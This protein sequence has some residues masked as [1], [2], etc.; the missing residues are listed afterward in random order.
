MNPLIARRLAAP[1]DGTSHVQVP[2]AA[3]ARHRIRCGSGSKTAA[4]VYRHAT[5][6]TTNADL[7]QSFKQYAEINGCEFVLRKND[8]LDALEQM[9]FRDSAGTFQLK[10]GRTMAARGFARLAINRSLHLSTS[11]SPSTARTEPIGAMIRSSV[12]VMA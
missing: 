10:Q 2:G 4:I 11:H 9:E 12:S 7:Y 6:L 3:R 5:A 1:R 8:L